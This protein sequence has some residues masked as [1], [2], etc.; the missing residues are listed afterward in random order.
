[1]KGLIWNCRGIKKKG[2]SFFL[3]N[4]ISEHNFHFISL[5][6]TM[7]EDIDEKTL[8]GFDPNSNYLWK[9]LPSRGKSGGI[10]SGINTDFLD[11][12]GFCEGK[13]I[14]QMDVWDKQLKQKWNFLNIYGAAQLEQKNEFLAELAHFC[15]KNNQPYLIRGDFNI[16]RFSSDKNKPFG[17][18]KHTDLFNNIISIYDLLDIHLVGGKYTWSNNQENPTLERLDRVLISKQWEDL[19]PSVFLYKLPREISDHNPLIL[20]TQTHQSEKN[21][22]QIRDLLAEGP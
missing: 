22:L 11:V 19:F 5:Q 4:L 8:K 6:E 13:Y 3:K 16:I 9:W 14:L 10:L 20:S 21:L 17:V 7:V 12:G 18:H 2:V 15:S 1:M